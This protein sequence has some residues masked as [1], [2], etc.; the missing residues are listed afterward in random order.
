MNIK[1]V[2]RGR[3]RGLKKNKNETIEK[4]NKNEQINKKKPREIKM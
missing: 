1:R 4:N 3:K 2:K